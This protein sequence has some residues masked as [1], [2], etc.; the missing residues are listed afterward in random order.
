MKLLLVADDGTILDSTDD[1]T[2]D[3][4]AAAQANPVGAMALLQELAVR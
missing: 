1:L 3:E 4:F 2:S